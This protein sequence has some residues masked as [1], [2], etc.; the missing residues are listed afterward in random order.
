MGPTFAKVIPVLNPEVRDLCTRPYHGHPKGCPNYGKRPSCPPA[1]PLLGEVLD[2]DHAVYAVWNRFD[3]A[4]H[5]ARM[6]ARH[7]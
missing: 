1:A 6:R 2:L 5:V 7:P 4:G 3:F